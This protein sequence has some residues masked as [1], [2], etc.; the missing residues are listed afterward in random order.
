LAFI[1]AAMAALAIL[2]ATQICD[3]NKLTAQAIVSGSLE[4]TPPPKASF[5]SALVSAISL[6]RDP[7]IWLLA[8]TNFCFGFSAALM[9]GYVNAAIAVPVLGRTWVAGLTALTVMVSI[10]CARL[11]GKLAARVGSLPVVS[12][13]ALAFFTISCSLLALGG[14]CG[15]WNEALVLLYCLQG[16]GRAVYE[17]TNRALFANFF[18]EDTEAAFA[19]CMLQS[20]LSF[21]LCF[22]LQ[23]SIG[24]LR[25]AMI[26][27]LLSP[28]TILGL[29]GANYLTKRRVSTRVGQASTQYEALGG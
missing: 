10:I 16:V 28:M 1:Y 26:I 14:G 15:S 8:P 29:I 25:L 22:F 12:T 19:N 17:S 18:P 7:I 24:G 2:P 4:E 23:A 13:G 27:V 9:N 11:F 6:W 21:A 20:A 3:I 5:G